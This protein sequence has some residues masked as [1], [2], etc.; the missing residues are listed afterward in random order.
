MKLQIL[1]LMMA[2]T[3][4]ANDFVE[5]PYNGLKTMDL[6]AGIIPSLSVGDFDGDGDLDVILSNE[7]NAALHGV[8]FYENPTGKRDASDVV[9][10]PPRKLGKGRAYLVSSR[11]ED[12]SY[13]FCDSGEF[14]TN[15]LQGTDALT[16]FKGLTKNIHFNNVRR[17][18]WRLKDYD[19]DGRTDLIVSVGDWTIY[20]WDNNYDE[21]GN[22]KRG[23]LHSYFYWLK[24]LG[25]DTLETT[26]WATPQLLTTQDGLPLDTYGNPSA[27]LEDWDGDGDLD[28]ITCDFLDN[29]WYFENCGTRINPVWSAARRICQRD[30]ERLN[31]DLCIPHMQAVDWDNDGRLDL[32]V[33]EEDGR[34]GFY[35]NDGRAVNGAPAF[36]PARY[37]QQQ[38]T[39]VNFGL[40]ATPCAFDWDGDG[41][42]D[43]LC[44]NSA[45]YIAFI[46]NLSGAGITNPAWAAPRKLTVGGKPF[47][48]MAGVNGSIQGPAEHKWG[49]TCLT[50]GDWDSDGR[51]DI[52]YNSIWGEI[53]LLRNLGK[54]LSAP[55]PVT[56]AWHGAQ[57]ELKW[58]WR[59]PSHL[60]SPD[61]ILTQWRTTPV[62]C[63]W[64]K[65]GL[66][67]LILID[68]EGY[69]AFW[70]RQRHGNDL[71]LLPPQRALVDENGAP[72]RL[73]G[74]QYPNHTPNIFAGGSGR[75]KVCVCD[76]NGDGLLDIIANGKNARIYLQTRHAD[77]KWFFCD[78]GDA[79][80][81]NLYGHSTAPTP[82]H[83]SPNALPSLLLG[84]ESGFLYLLQN[85]LNK[86]P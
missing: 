85:P 11:M 26:T 40:L 30:G 60:S 45:G 36:A 24:N 80:P 76:W 53:M 1:I 31:C 77:G 21:R 41:D 19:G 14:T 10:L 32:L 28:L 78:S 58:G 3:A 39:T 38:A 16:P 81:R 68:H 55:E 61:A 20:G 4:A 84:T 82:L 12:G 42:E 43:I 44:G 29:F 74:A 48:V 8:W 46:E 47:R 72:L 37:L 6:K 2:A 50:V 17:N 65:D 69:L 49:Y 13:I 79:A 59:K 9:F 23:P 67:D 86:A 63:D 70:Q 5:L 33:S 66:M 75:R 35:H 22:W 18:D 34:V 62:M 57:P 54:E 56:A 83:L 15:T 27:L 73:A 7:G 71:I 52:I 25:G 51:P 64:N